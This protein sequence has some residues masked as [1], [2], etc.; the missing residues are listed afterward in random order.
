[1]PKAV[2]ALEKLGNIRRQ[3]NLMAVK[4]LRDQHL[5]PKQMIMLRFIHAQGEVS[6]TQLARGTA[7]DMAAASRAIGPLVH[8]G[9]LQKKRNPDDSRCWII[10]LT[11]TARRKMLKVNQIYAKLADIMAG[12]LNKRERDVLLGLLTKVSTGLTTSLDA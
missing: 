5:H 2:Q 6:L 4:M 9:W 8:N 10:G 7:T 3:I 11:P 1:M 12:P